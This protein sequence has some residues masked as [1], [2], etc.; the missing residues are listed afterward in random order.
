MPPNVPI[1]F[2]LNCVYVCVCVFFTD[3][4]G[5]IGGCS[6][7]RFSR[8]CLRFKPMKSNF[9][10]S[11]S[12]F[13]FKSCELLFQNFPHES[14]NFFSL[15]TSLFHRFQK[16]LS[17]S[18]SQPTNIFFLPTLLGVM[19][20]A[21]ISMRLSLVLPPAYYSAVLVARHSFFLLQFFFAITLFFLFTGLS[22]RFS[23]FFQ[24]FSHFAFLL[25]SL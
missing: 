11:T 12:S 10:F 15:L 17:L 25:R 20:I 21:F 23:P 2:G 19:R 9:N 14:C 3:V 13:S 8:L 22:F 18:L 7:F 16:L 6:V 5:V 4:T 24:A 1:C